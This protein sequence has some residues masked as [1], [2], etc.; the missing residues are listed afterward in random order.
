[1]AQRFFTPNEQ[2]YD[3]AGNPMAG[4]Q[5]FF[6]A[7]GTSTPQNTFNDS[8]LTI[9]NPN[10]VVL[11]SAG[12]AGSIFLGSNAYKVVLQDILGNLIWTFDPVSNPPSAPVFVGGPSTGSANS[13]VVLV[14][15][16][17]GFTLAAGNKLLFVAGFTNTTGMTL[18]VGGIP[19]TNLSKMSSV[20]LVSLSGGEVQAGQLQEV[21]CDGSHL[22]LVSTGGSVGGPSSATSGNVALFDGGSGSFIK[23]SLFSLGLLFRSYLAGLT[24]SND[25]GAPTTVLDISAGTSMSDDQTTVMNSGAFTKNCNASWSAG[26][27]NGALDSGVLL[28]N[29]TWYH[30]Y[31][32]KRPDTGLVDF[33]ISTNA[34][35]PALPTSY[36]KKRRIG[37][38]LTDGSGHIL[39]FYQLDDWFYWKTPT[40]DVS[41]IAF[42]T[43]AANYTIN[44]PPGVTVMAR[45]IVGV[46]ASSGTP[47]I[48]LYNPL[49]TDD[50]VT[51]QNA[52]VGGY[53]SA[54]VGSGQADILTNTAQQIRAI[55]N[56]ATG[57]PTLS[58]RTTA[59]LDYRGRFN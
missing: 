26:S 33:I 9:A 14:T 54:S 20:G 13:Q 10:P 53:G 25:S 44:V 28:A 6:F 21:D 23:D 7:S 42:G 16:P 5:L 46:S 11:D 35:S 39:A 56:T 22:I 55:G 24:L 49:S 50:I 12:R 41:A 37:S 17:S 40:Q 36:T 4:G 30:V 15:T 31:Q 48:Y 43:T 57:S 18:T 8:G 32:I 52:T 58:W 59:W 29:S 2:F 45:G 51:F 47:E 27:G 3:G 19:A 38:I 1:M 34:T